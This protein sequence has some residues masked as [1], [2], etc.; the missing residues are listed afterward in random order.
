MMDIEEITKMLNGGG[1]VPSK[2]GINDMDLD[3]TTTKKEYKPYNKNSSFNKS[4]TKSNNFKK[5]EPI[6]VDPI[7]LDANKLVA[8]NIKTFAIDLMSI[9]LDKHEVVKKLAEHL[10]SKGFVYRSTL[11][12]D[13]TLSDEQYKN[14]VEGN[15]LLDLLIRQLPNSK[16]EGYIPWKNYNYEATGKEIIKNDEPSTLSFQYAHN[17]NKF[18][19]EMSE[20]VKK[21]LGRQIYTFLG[22]NLNN[23]TNVIITYTKCGNVKIVKNFNFKEAK[24]AVTYLK[25][26]NDINASIFNL[27]S[28]NV[29]SDFSTY[30][31]SII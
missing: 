5:S 11:E 30:L 27:G 13:S 12:G 17:Y 31:K 10:F 21:L 2:D 3:Q 20:G 22:E 19:N 26:G 8:S 15:K 14:S 1:D 4:Y 6:K 25:L 9:P 23:P 29:I 16:I 7:S 28:D 24:R 18:F